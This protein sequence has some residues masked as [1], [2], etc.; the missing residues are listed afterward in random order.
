MLAGECG[1]LSTATDA[2]GDFEFAGLKDGSDVSIEID[3]PGR[4][5]YSVDIKTDIDHN[6]GVILLEASTD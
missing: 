2:F 5:T 6:L 3:A 4:K 1:T